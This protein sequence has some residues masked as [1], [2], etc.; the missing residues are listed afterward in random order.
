M[1]RLP[2]ALLSSWSV[3]LDVLETTVVGGSVSSSASEFP[4]LPSLV[5]PSP[6]SSLSGGEGSSCSEA[7]AAACFS[8]AASAAM[9]AGGGGW[10]GPGADEVEAA[11]AGGTGLSGGAALH[12]SGSVRCT[13]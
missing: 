13:A 8:S 10:R 5:T 9:A 7:S 3:M 4:L 11:G 6:L 1:G 2:L 12:P